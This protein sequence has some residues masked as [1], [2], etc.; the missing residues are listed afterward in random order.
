MHQPR[1]GLFYLSCWKITGELWFNIFSI[2]YSLVYL[3]G[4]NQEVYGM[5][6]FRTKGRC[7][8]YHH[9]QDLTDDSF[10]NIGL[11][12]YNRK[13]QDLG[14]YEITKNPDDVGKFKTPSLRDLMLTRPWM[15]NG[16]FDSLEGIVNRYNSGMHMID[17][18]AEKKATDPLY[19]YTD[20]LMQPLKLSR[21]EVKAIVAFL[22]SLSG[23]KYKMKRP[24]F[25]KA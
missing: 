10:H 1:T 19:P 18:S 5:H 25:P 14:R 8:N 9:G 11:T 7:M 16:F 4:V 22:E 20:P 24:D 23:T 2:R 21:E 17:P 6:L 3:C 15:H 12:Y 13:F